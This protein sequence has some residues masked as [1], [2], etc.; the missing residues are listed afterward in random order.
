MVSGGLA[1]VYPRG[2]WADA[3]A[4]RRHGRLRLLWHWEDYSDVVEHWWIVR[5]SVKK[6]DQ[7]KT[8]NATCSIL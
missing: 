8:N 4:K 3:L 1:R 6:S 5:R 2:L 7:S